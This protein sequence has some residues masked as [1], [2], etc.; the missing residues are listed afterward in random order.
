LMKQMLGFSWKGLLTIYLQSAGA[1]LAALLPTAL[2]Y[3]VLAGPDRAGLGQLAL[4]AVLGASC[5]LIS[6]RLLRHPAYREVVATAG[7]LMQA[8][9]RLRPAPS[10]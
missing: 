4:S 7:H 10:A 9:P 1:T 3:G 2:F 8:L 6:L 5:W